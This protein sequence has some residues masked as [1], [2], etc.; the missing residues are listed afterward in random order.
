MGI[1]G[2]VVANP[3]GQVL[4]PGERVEIYR[5]LQADPKLNRKKRAAEK[6]R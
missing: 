1:F 2:K 4:K 3:A 6:A 5:P